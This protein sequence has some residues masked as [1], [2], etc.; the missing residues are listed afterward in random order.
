[1]P[2]GILLATL[3]FCWGLWDYY[4]SERPSSAAFVKAIVGLGA[5]GFLIA[6]SLFG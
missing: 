3:V 2:V 4:H 5:V 1:M 6:R